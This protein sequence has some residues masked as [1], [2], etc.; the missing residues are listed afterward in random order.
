VSGA[1]AAQTFTVSNTGTG[2]LVIGTLSLSGG[3]AANFTKQND[4]CTGQTVIPAGSCTVEIKFT[5][6]STGP[7][8]ASLSIPSNY[9]TAAT[10]SLSGTGELQ[11][12][13]TVN[14]NGSTGTGTVTSGPSGISCGADCSEPYAN[15]AVVTLTAAPDAGSSFAG[16]SGGGCSG[17]GSCVVTINSNTAVTA[18]FNTIPPIADFSGTPVSGDALLNVSFTDSSSNNPVSWSWTFGDGGT[19]TAQNPSHIYE[20]PGTYTV[21]LTATNAGGPSTTTKT[22]YITVTSLPLRISGAPPSYY[23]S[24]TAAYG[25]AAGGD[26][27]QGQAEVFTEDLNCNRN[28]SVTLKGGY[29]ATFAGNT[30][31]TTING[32]LTITSGTVTVENIVIQ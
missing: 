25:A 13:L 26:A 19:S 30:G 7:K 14:K 2:N 8:T 9:P 24:L 21:S 10:A 18:I 1:S 27:I 6:S 16:W 32:S 15:G 5:P 4:N 12:T 3:D 17:T 23:S 22:N 20:D 11:Y 28:I 31:F 29:D